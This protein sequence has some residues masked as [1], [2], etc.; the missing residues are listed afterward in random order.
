MATTALNTVDILA[1]LVAC[2]TVSRDSNKPLIDW[3]RNYLGDIG[4]DSH[5]VPDAAGGK[6]NLFASVGPYEEGGIILSGHTDVVPVDGQSWSSDPFELT[7]RG[8]RLHARG[9]CD[10]KGFIA[11]TLAQVPAWKA[12]QLTRPVHLM[13]SYDEEVGCLGAPS[14][15]VAAKQALP[16]PSAVFV[17][18]PTNMRV[19]NQHKGICLL[20]TCVKGVEAHSSLTHQ[21]LSAVMLA[22]EL[23]A[24]LQ[25]LAD[26]LAARAAAEAPTPASCHLEPPYTTISVNR[27]Q[28][29][30][31]INILAAVCEFDWDIRTLPGDTSAGLLAALSNLATVRLAQLFREGKRCEVKTSVRTDVPPLQAHAGFAEQLAHA[32]NASM[33]TP[34]GVPFATEGGL[35]QAAGWSTVVCGP[36]SIE[37]AHKPDEYIE[38]TELA[39]CDA[40]LRRAV[41]RQC[42]GEAL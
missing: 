34:I 33:T 39:A 42:L 13:F 30:T 7:S 11:A 12:S 26:D 37:Q 36:G 31:A 8:T 14:M 16:T 17:G 10:M 23:I 25:Q 19:A 35:F 32:A 24:K 38:R 21:G 15:I 22:G 28:G 18:E 27:I 20:R 1:R 6:F 9:A 4:I 29:G 5:L 40:F 2:P 3:I 41:I